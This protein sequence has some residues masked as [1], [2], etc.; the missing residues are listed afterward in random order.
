LEQ[1][2]K[3]VRSLTEPTQMAWLIHPAEVSKTLRLQLADLG[4][5]SS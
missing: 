5:R 4:H 3:L 1:R 2:S